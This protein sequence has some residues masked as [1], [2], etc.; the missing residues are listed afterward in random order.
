MARNWSAPHD[1]GLALT[2]HAD[3]SRGLQTHIDRER[4]G[5]QC[6]DAKHHCEGHRAISVRAQHPVV[7]V[8]P[9]IAGSLRRFLPTV[10]SRHL[11][12]QSATPAPSRCGASTA[13]APTTSTLEQDPA[14]LA[15]IT[16]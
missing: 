7:F 8:V 15:A 14:V 4:E 6:N 16:D 12:L 11:R 1:H 5:A 10:F 3:H 13:T 9:R 2:I